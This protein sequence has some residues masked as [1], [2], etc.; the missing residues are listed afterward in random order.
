LPRKAFLG[1]P[2]FKRDVLVGTIFGRHLM[3]LGIWHQAVCDL[4][5]FA[6]MHPVVARDNAGWNAQ[7]RSSAGLMPINSSFWRLAGFLAITSLKMFTAAARFHSAL[8]GS[9]NK[10][11]IVVFGPAAV[12]HRVQLKDFWD[13]LN[14]RTRNAITIRD[15]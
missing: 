9:L 1:V 6:R 7:E 5:G 3:I 2:V 10:P 15:S 14:G 8:L 13:D 11:R 12:P 4:P